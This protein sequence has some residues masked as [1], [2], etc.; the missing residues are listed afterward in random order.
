MTPLPPH[1]ADISRPK[2]LDLFSGAGGAARGYQWAGF[3]VTGV[4]NRPQPRYAGDAFVQADALEYLAEHGREFNAVHASPPCQAYIRSGM[5]AKDGRHP[6]L[7]GPTR[8]ALIHNGVFWVI[9]NV[10][11]APMRPDVVLCGTMFGLGVRRHR[12]FES[13]AGLLPFTPGCNHS[14]PITGIYGHPHVRGGAWR[15]GNKPMLPS[16]HTTWSREMDIDWMRPLELAAA[17][18][19][20]YTEWIGRQLSKAVRGREA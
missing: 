19:P 15:N 12:W 3:H 10:P 9:E 6:D 11:G 2:L 4:D 5:V 1:L 14:Y 8:E 17:I 13:N 20:A 16:D 7:I 18:P